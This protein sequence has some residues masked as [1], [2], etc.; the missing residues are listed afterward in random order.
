MHKDKDHHE[1]VDV[2]VVVEGE[3]RFFV[4]LRWVKWISDWERKD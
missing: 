1:Q 4:R 3:G 2:R